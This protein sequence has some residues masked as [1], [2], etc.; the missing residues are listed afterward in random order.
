LAREDIV[1]LLGRDDVED[2]ELVSDRGEETVAV[3]G[4]L[5][6]VGYRGMGEKS[7]L[8]DGMCVVERE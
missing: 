3:W 1:R 2:G 6:V 8:S 5:F 7:E 4:N